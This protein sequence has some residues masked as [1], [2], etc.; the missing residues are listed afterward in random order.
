MRPHAHTDVGQ[1][2]QIEDVSYT[3]SGRAYEPLSSNGG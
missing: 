1:A 2:A 3:R